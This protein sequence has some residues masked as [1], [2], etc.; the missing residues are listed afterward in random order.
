MPAIEE[1]TIAAEPVKEVPLTAKSA[2]AAAVASLEPAADDK[3]E[4]DAKEEPK[5]ETKAAPTKEEEDEEKLEVANARQLYNAL[6]DPNTRD[7]VIEFIAKQGGYTRGAAA[8]ETKAEI[9]EAKD[10]IKAALEEALGAEFSFLTEKLGPALD[11]IITKKLQDGLTETK[12]A[13]AEQEQE[14][15]TAKSE[16]TLTKLSTD[17]FQEEELPANVKAGMKTYMDKVQP[18]EDMDIKDYIEMAFYS[19]IGRLGITRKDAKTEAKV[20][21]NRTDAAARLASDR[22]P[23]SVTADTTKIISRKDAIR[24]AMESIEAKEA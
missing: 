17:F 1:K 23:G 13:L 16:R 3:K 21:K 8:P 20:T 19:T 22:G 2:V 10:E 5:K 6:K 24:A 9:K 11:K 14:K 7:N 18:T 12:A 4:P 15:L